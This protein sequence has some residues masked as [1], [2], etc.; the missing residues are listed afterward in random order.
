MCDSL[1]Q[2]WLEIGKVSYPDATSILILADGGGSNSSRHYIFKENLQKLANKIK[3]E[4]RMA[5]YPPYTSKW[6]PIEH[7]V[8]PHITRAVKGILLGSHSF[9]KKLIEGVKTKNGLKIIASITKNI[10]AHGKKYSQEFKE[11]IPILFDDQLG[12]WNYRARP[13]EVRNL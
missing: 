3:I 8:F 5:H 7:R 1:E 6:N 2:W 4:L 13:Q 12:K 9:Y 11:N 10:Y